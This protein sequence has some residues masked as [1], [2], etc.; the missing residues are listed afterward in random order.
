[1]V[2]LNWNVKALDSV[3][4]WQT[5]VAVSIDFTS[6]HACRHKLSPKTGEL[7]HQHVW[8]DDQAMRCVV[9]PSLWSCTMKENRMQHVC[10]ATAWKGTQ[11]V[12]PT[13]N[14][15]N[16]RSKEN[17]FHCWCQDLLSGFKKSRTSLKALHF[18]FGIFWRGGVSCPCFFCNRVFC[19]A[20]AT[21]VDFSRQL[22]IPHSFHDNCVAQE[23]HLFTLALSNLGTVILLLWENRI[24]RLLRWL[25]WAC[26]WSL[27]S[28]HTKIF[29]DCCNV[30]HDKTRSGAQKLLNCAQKKTETVQMASSDPFYLAIASK[31]NIVDNKC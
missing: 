19:T 21:E 31:S 6:T 20:G 14:G 30:H 10:H 22:V 3:W 16:W 15:S 2:N 7:T 13:E 26:F 9:Q 5:A 11:C 12:S 24:T 27:F 8:I 25:T 28:H 18:A 17:N 29:H 4:N 1:M 23:F